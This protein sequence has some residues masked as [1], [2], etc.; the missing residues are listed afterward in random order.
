V[1]W[2]RVFLN[3][4]KT[5]CRFLSQTIYRW[6]FIMK[7]V[8]IHPEENKGLWF[9]IDT[10]KKN[11]FQAYIAGGAVRDFLLHKKPDDVDIL[12]NAS[13]KEVTFLFQGQN[14]KTMG[15]TFPICCVNGIE[16]S[17]GRAK[18]DLKSFPE[19]DLGQRDFTINSMALDPISK[20]IIDPFN[21]KKDLEDAVI[22]FTKDPEQRITEDP[23]RM[24]RACRFA[25]AINGSFS[26][27]SYTLILAFRDLLDTSVAKERIHGEVIKAMGLKK[28]SLFFA[29]L[30]KTGLLSKIFPSLDRCHGLEGGPH[31]GETVF[32]HCMM[33]G[34]AL[35]GN[36]PILRL[37]GFLHDVGKFDAARQSDGS[38]TFAGHENDTRAVIQ[39]LERL[40]FAK[41]DIDYIVSLIRIHMRPLTA[42][43]SPKA[44]RRLL[45]RLADRH[46]DFRDFMRMRIADKK[47]NLAKN[48]YTIAEIRVRLKKVFDQMEGQTA[49]H[50]NHL[51]ING[52]DI[53]RILGLE[54]GPDIGRIKQ[55]LF[56]MVLDDPEVNHYNELKNRCSCLQIKK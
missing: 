3:E 18:F 13:I 36:R 55:Q 33:V 42:Q 9:I 24:I 29:A 34:D 19:S 10:L 46:L 53:I 37:A 56:E 16:I 6:P 48:P 4:K 51:M 21:G 47:G 39:D 44:V 38:L 27:S 2:Y 40:R 11:G 1:F 41:K 52:N 23:V 45:A 20:K 32:E 49:F 17:S 30:K 7:E 54:P 5:D 25:A 28:P 26:L 43:S 12:T 8:L 14:V 15:K 22:R 35:P 50:M 31:H